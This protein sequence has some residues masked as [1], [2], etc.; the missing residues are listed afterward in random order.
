[1]ADGSATTA[2]NLVEAAVLEEIANLGE[3]VFEHDDERLPGITKGSESF[4]AHD[5]FEAISDF[6]DALDLVDRA[7]DVIGEISEFLHLRVGSNRIVGVRLDAAHVNASSSASE[8][9]LELDSEGGEDPRNTAGT[10]PVYR[11]LGTGSMHVCHSNGVPRG[12]LVGNHIGFRIFD[13]RWPP[14]ST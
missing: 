2:K 12:R 3:N 9:M 8:E 4:P 6:F 14:L 5:N 10:S 13:A 11:H 1:M 7:P